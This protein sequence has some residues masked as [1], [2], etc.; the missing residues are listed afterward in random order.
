MKILITGASGN[1]G[2]A[3]LSKFTQSDVQ[4]FAGVRDAQRSKTTLDNGCEYCALDLEKGIYPDIDFDA[5]FLMRPPQLAHP[6]IFENF[7]KTLNPSTKIVFLSVYGA[8]KRHYLPHAKIEKVISRNGFQHVFIR[9]C[10]FMENLTTTLWKELKQ[11]KRIYLPSSNL[12]FQWVAVDDIAEVSKTALLQDVRSEAVNVCSDEIYGFQEVIN[13]INSICSTKFSYK[14]PSLIKYVM[15]NIKSHEKLSFTLVMLL[16]HFLPRF[17]KQEA[18]PS[19]D[20][21]QIIGRN[22]VSLDDFIERNCKQFAGLT[23]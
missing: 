22:P 7:L 13:K 21:K 23:E 4:L 5:I 14:S 11:N 3:I 1:V 10:Y 20:I 9:P 6:E 19:S 15:Y 8:D 18:A 2:R 12:K 17:G 16:L